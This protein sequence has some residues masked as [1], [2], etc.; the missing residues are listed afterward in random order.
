MNWFFEKRINLL[1]LF[2]LLPITNYNILALISL[3]LLFFVK[4]YNVSVIFNF[5]IFLF[6]GFFIYSLNPNIT[7]FKYLLSIIALLFLIYCKKDLDLSFFNKTTF[8]LFIGVLIESSFLR[9]IFRS[10]YRSSNVALHYDRY[11]S[12]FLFPGDLGAYCAIAISLHFLYLVVSDSNKVNYLNFIFILFNFIILLLSQ[13]RMAFLHIFI[14]FLIFFFIKPRFIFF[15]ILFIPFIFLFQ[16]K[17]SY[18]FREDFFYLFQSFFSS[19]ASIGNKRAQEIFEILNS[20]EGDSGYYEGSF[21]SFIS[22]FGF[23]ISSVIFFSVFI[24]FY[25]FW[26]KINNKFSSLIVILPIIFTSIISAPLE[27][28]KLLFFSFAAILLAAN[29]SNLFGKKLNSQNN[30]I[31]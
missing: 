4:R 6:F 25:N 27:R 22:R 24:S 14:S 12:F 29:I 19:E 13:S 30:E 31:I 3:F 8:I 21:P 20:T 28:P 16:D 11:S 9:D 23:I 15:L 5:F 1:F 2:I 18:L 26:Y 7:I 10:F 17:L